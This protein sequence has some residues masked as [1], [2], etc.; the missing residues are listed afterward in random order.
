MF[1]VSASESSEAE[2]NGVVAALECAK[3]EMVECVYGF[4]YRFTTDSE[5]PYSDMDYSRQAHQVRAFYPK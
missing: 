1:S 4:H 2:A 3:V 5:R